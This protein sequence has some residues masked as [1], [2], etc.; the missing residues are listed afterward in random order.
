MSNEAVGQDSSTLAEPQP[1]Y[2]AR[3]GRY[4]LRIML[5]VLMGVFVGAGLYFGAPALLQAV[6]EPVEQNRARI[7]QLEAELERQA[8]RRQQDR[9]ALSADVSGLEGELAQANE[10]RSELEAQLTA[11]QSEVQ[12]LDERAEE[13]PVLQDE[14][15]SL[16][17]DL[18]AIES[19][20]AEFEAEQ[21]ESRR[22]L[23]Q[24]TSDVRR[25]EALHFVLQARTAIAADEIESAR[26]WIE[27]AQTIL[28]D[29]IGRQATPQPGSSLARLQLALDQLDQSPEAADRDLQTAAELMLAQA[30]ESPPRR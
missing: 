8:D 1:S 11:L 22:Q 17:R 15:D 7:L 5:V 12:D 25:L 14:I 6:M 10:Q 19:E 24:L 20:F 30:A 27:A 13:L 4:L 21:A 23:E 26:T 2:A 9:Q 3:A 16:R 29:D 18:V 28:L